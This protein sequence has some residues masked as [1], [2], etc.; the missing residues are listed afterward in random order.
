MTAPEIESP[1]EA[2]PDGS[3]R[4]LIKRIALIAATGY[5]APKAVMISEP[6]ACDRVGKPAPHGNC[7]SGP[8][9]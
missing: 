3:R 4:R 1:T 2:V 7:Q 8:F 5:L 6:W 9:C